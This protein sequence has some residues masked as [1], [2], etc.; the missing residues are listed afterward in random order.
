MVLTNPKVVIFDESTSALD[1]HTERALFEGLEDFLRPK[2]VIIIAHRLSTVTQAQYIYVLE[3]GKILQEGRREDLEH[4]E[5]HFHHFV[6]KN[7]N[8]TSLWV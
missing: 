8:I 1:V 4:Q 6:H 2:T 3:N 7:G 5:G